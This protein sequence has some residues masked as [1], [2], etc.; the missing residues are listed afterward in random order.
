MNARTETSVLDVTSRV[1]T[2]PEV[3]RADLLSEVRS[4]QL[5]DAG[6]LVT[7]VD[8]TRARVAMFPL[9]ECDEDMELAAL[10]CQEV[11]RLWKTLEDQRTAYTGPLNKAV[12]AIND[13]YRPALT[14]LESGEAALKSVM[15]AWEQRKQ[16]LL[17]EERRAAAEREAAERARIAAE[18]RRLEA[19][20]EADRQREAAEEAERQR[21]AQQAADALLSQAAAA[22]AAG[23]PQ[24]AE[25]ARRAAEEAERRAQEDAERAREQA[26][27]RDADARAQASALALT[28]QVLTASVMLPATRR[29]AGVSARANLVVEVTDLLA[30]VKHIADHPELIGLLKSDDSAIKNYCKGLGE[31]AR[32]PGV[33]VS[34]GAPSMAVRSR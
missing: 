6:E 20:R 8:D 30:L 15:G 32:L 14:A 33:V 34:H 22:Q 24:A 17:L 19:E 28:S 2:A 27:A 4:L 18:Q 10:E 23:D 12:K 31:H 16:Q 9:V 13:W 5:P 29:P 26:A 21:R 25:R 3:E 1:V 11:K 7:V